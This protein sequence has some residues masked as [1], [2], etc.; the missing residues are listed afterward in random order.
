MSSCCTTFDID[1]QPCPK[2]GQVGPIVGAAP[3]RAHRAD[4]T[5]GDWQ[6]CANERCDVIFH[7]GA[8]T[9]DDDSVRAQ[10]GLKASD[11]ATPVCFCFA[12]T[13]DALIH[14]VVAHGGVSE[15]K[16][17]IKAAV[18]NSECACE[19]LNPSGSCCLADVHRILNDLTLPDPHLPDQRPD[20]VRPPT[21]RL[22]TTRNPR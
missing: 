1:A 16:A 9:V 7:L 20:R 11:K 12:H 3:V 4:A 8:N 18:A 2:C 14:D 13:A 5:D 6:H 19:H 21:T 15:I 10:V 17:S 22:H